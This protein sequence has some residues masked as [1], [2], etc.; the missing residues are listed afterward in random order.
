V[1]DEPV[2]DL[3][4]MAADGFAALRSQGVP[5][6]IV[7][8]SEPAPEYRSWLA[9]VLPQATITVFEGSGHFPHLAHPD[10]FASLL[11]GI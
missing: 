11:A 2:A 6:T 10:R 8:G 1:L 7:T 5:C 3:A 4:A 9:E